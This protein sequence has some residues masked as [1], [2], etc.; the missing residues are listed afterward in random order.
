LAMTTCASGHFHAQK[1]PISA[2]VNWSRARKEKKEEA[3][4]LYL[5]YVSRS[6]FLAKIL[7]LRFLN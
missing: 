2:N 4:R 3:A 6:V 1:F 7:L 5:I